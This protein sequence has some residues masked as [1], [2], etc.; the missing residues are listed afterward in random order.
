M[1]FVVAKNN[2]CTATPLLRPFN[3]VMFQ[4]QSIL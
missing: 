2:D 4:L 3:L 1:A